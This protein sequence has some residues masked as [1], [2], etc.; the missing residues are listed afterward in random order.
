MQTRRSHAFQRKVTSSKGSNN[1]KIIRPM[2]MVESCGKQVVWYKIL[3]SNNQKGMSAANFHFLCICRSRSHGALYHFKFAW[4]R[5]NFIHKFIS[6]W[7][8]VLHWVPHHIWTVY[9]SYYH[10]KWI[11]K[12][13]TMKKTK[14]SYIFVSISLI[15]QIL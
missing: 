10:Q 8:K 11:T 3:Q 1:W 4:S 12:L 6:N 5:R 13:P 9:I 2:Y 7:L 14:K 15:Q